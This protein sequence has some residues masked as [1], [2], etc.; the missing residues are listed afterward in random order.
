[1]DTISRH[2]AYYIVTRK[3]L[4]ILIGCKRVIT[5]GSARLYTNADGRPV[6]ST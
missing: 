4:L 5:R 3:V 6:K 1:M 2:V